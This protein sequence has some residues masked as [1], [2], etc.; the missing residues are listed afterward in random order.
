MKKI[1]ELKKFV[2]GREPARGQVWKHKNGGVYMV[3]PHAGKN[4]FVLVCVENDI[5]GNY[6]HH[7]SLWG[8]HTREDFTY[9]GMFDSLYQR[10]AQRP[11]K[12][13]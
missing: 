7:D 9:I 4:E 12:K 10:K 5:V 8:S 13:L 6:W 1:E 11:K 2:E 3:V